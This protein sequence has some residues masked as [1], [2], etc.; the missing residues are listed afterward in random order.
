MADEQVDAVG[1]RPFE[2]GTILSPAEAK[3]REVVQE[4]PEEGFAVALVGLRVEDV[5]VPEEIDRARGTDLP[6][7]VPKV[8][9]QKAPVQGLRLVAQ[10]RGH[11]LLLDELVLQEG[12]VEGV[13]LA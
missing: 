10:L 3:V 6:V 13:H 8:Q 2:V 4:A 7:G 5:R 12:E 9:G 1:E 11:A